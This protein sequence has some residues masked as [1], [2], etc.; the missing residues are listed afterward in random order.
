MVF[1]RK[2]TKSVEREAPAVSSEEMQQGADQ[3]LSELRRRGVE[4]PLSPSLLKGLVGRLERVSR[5]SRA[6]VL[7]G[8]ALT[9]ELQDR[10]RLQMLRNLREIEEVEQMM[11]SFSGELSK[12]DEVMEVLSAY[13][14]RLHES[15]RSRENQLLH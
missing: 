4:A 7:D 12:L 15:G 1:W 9:F 13:V 6:S 3:I 11:N 5:E 14:K 2:R 8:I 10:T